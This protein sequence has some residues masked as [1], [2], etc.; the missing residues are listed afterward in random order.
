MIKR[1]KSSFALFEILEKASPD[2]L[3]SKAFDIAIVILILLNV[4][5]VV[6]ESVYPPSSEYA[7]ELR[8]FE[9]CSIFFYSVEYILRL[10]SCTSVEKYERPV[11]GRIRFALNPVV[12]TDLL[13]VASFYLPLIFVLDLRFV[14]FL[15]FFKIVFHSVGRVKKPD[16]KT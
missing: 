15:R 11:I 8:I 4:A 1:N 14:R 10:W 6:F 2:D 7:T 3:P 16:E 5:A 12:V 13:A 9:I